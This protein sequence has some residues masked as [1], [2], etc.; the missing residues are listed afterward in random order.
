MLSTLLSCSV[1]VG[2]PIHL[3]QLLGE[4]WSALFPWLLVLMGCHKLWANFGYLIP[5]NSSPLLK[6]TCKLSS[7]LCSMPNEEKLLGPSKKTAP[8]Q[9]F[10]F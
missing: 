4:S 5:R 3:A 8:P 7:F 1:G 6:R 10:Q 2:H 9:V